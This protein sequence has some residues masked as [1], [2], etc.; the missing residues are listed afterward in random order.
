MGLKDGSIQT[1]QKKPGSI[2]D[3]IK[4]HAEGEVWGLSPIEGSDPLKYIT[5]CDD[6][7]IFLYDVEMRKV[8][9]KGKVSQDET[10]VGSKGKQFKGG[11][12]TLST[13]K[14]HCQSRAVAY[15]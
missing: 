11:A 15:N 6:N 10:E 12:S 3:L 13:K 7:V 14:P 9:G 1:S 4:S 8:T 5:S 2:R